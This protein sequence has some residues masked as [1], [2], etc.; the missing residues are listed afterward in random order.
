VQ[1]LSRLPA[2]ARGGVA[3]TSGP[4]GIYVGCRREAPFAETLRIIPR[5]L[6]LGVGCRR[7]ATETQITAAVDAVLAR[8]RIDPRAIACL[9]SIDL[10]ADEPGLLAYARTAGLPTRFYPAETLSALPGEFSPSAFVRSVTGV[11]AV[12]ERAAMMGADRLIV[13]KQIENSVTVAVAAE[14]LEV[15]FG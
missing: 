13:R 9:A 6:H 2:A 3:G 15:S 14:K 10:K 7:G 1:R 4:L 12:C 5:A 8:E 11:D